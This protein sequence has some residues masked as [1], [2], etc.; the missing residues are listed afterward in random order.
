MS[1][2]HSVRAVSLVDV[3]YLQETFANSKPHLLILMILFLVCFAT[4]N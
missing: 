3:K 1:V 4:I 2:R